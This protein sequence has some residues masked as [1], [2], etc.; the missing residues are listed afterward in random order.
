M[1]GYK[2]VVSIH[3]SAEKML[4]RTSMAKFKSRQ[5]VNTFEVIAV[6]HFVPGTC[7]HLLL[8]LLIGLTLLHSVSES[9]CHRS[10]VAWRRT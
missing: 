7:L 5:D 10:P 2:G 3:L 4:L 6:S 1:A 8:L 9:A